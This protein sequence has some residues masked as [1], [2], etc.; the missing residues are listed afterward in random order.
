M[1][2]G[3]Q[4]PIY[5]FPAPDS[6]FAAALRSAILRSSDFVS[7]DRL[8]ELLQ[9]LHMLHRGESQDSS[10]VILRINALS[11]LTDMRIRE[12]I[13]SVSDQIAEEYGLHIQP[14]ARSR[15]HDLIRIGEDSGILNEVERAKINRLGQIVNVAFLAGYACPNEAAI[16]AFAPSVKFYADQQNIY[17]FAH[18]YLKVN[19]PQYNPEEYVGRYLNGL[20]R[21]GFEVGQLIRNEVANKAQ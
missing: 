7:N 8:E 6:P 10:E 1:S 13:K 17:E 14:D 4:K 5:I 11:L 12:E 9:A 3:S 2:E 16:Q 15:T 20:M 18:E 19:N 21:C